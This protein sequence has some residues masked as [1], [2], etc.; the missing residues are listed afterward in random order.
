MGGA[1][2]RKELR[3]GSDAGSLPGVW[4]CSL[5]G[6]QSPSCPPAPTWPRQGALAGAGSEFFFLP[7]SFQRP[8][9]RTL[10]FSFSD[11]VQHLTGDGLNQALGW[12]MTLITKLGFVNVLESS[13]PWASQAQTRKTQSRWVCLQQ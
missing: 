12:R 8:R 7:L 2:S 9:E 3:E 11:R 13:L 4:L 10:D 6:T 5:P 1:V